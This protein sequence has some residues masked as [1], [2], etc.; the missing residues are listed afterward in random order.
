MQHV[1][2]QGAQWCNIKDGDAPG[3]CRV[4]FVFEV[5]VEDGEEGGLGLAQPCG[6]DEEDVV[7]FEDFGDGFVLGF[8]RCAD[9]ACGK[10]RVDAGVEEVEDGG[11]GMDGYGQW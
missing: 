6:C 7:A 4:F 5:L 3:L 8:S 2:V 11:H 10:E 9:A 1:P